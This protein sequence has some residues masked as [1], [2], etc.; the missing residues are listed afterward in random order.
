MLTK[1]KSIDPEVHEKAIKDLEACKTTVTELQAEREQL[2]EA[3]NK[4]SAEFD[5]FR[6]V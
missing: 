2:S 1:S 4:L 6:I 5:A 3:R